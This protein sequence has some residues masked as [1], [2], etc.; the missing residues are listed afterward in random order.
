MIF[1]NLKENLMNEIQRRTGIS[2]TDKS[3]LNMQK[4]LKKQFFFFF[5]VLFSVITI[6]YAS[7]DENVLSN[8]TYIYAAFII[9][10]LLL[11]FILSAQLFDVEREDTLSASTVFLGMGITIFI[12]IGISYFF[13]NASASTFITLNY[14]LGI[15][16]FFVIIGGLAVFYLIFSN[17][18]KK[19]VGAT[20]FFIKL[21]FYIPCLYYDFIAYLKEELK[22]TPS[23]VFIIAALEVIYILLYY[24]LPKLYNYIIKSTNHSILTGPV[25][26]NKEL[27]ISKNDIFIKKDGDSNLK[28]LKNNYVNSNYSISF[29]TYV[30]SGGESN[31]SYI[32]ESTIFNYAG[33]KPKVVYTNNN[34]KP[35]TYI[36]YFTNNEEE[37]VGPTSYEITLPSQKWNNFV[38]NYFNNKADLFI[39]G[40]LERTFVFDQSN[41]P[42]DGRDSDFISVGKNGGLDGAICNVNYNKNILSIEQIRREY[43]FMKYRNPPIIK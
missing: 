34:N 35:D 21:L 1:N 11:G 19:Q 31:S 39:N 6:Y 15:I 4:D 26:L 42:Y 40:K 17:Y 37:N 2:F 43:N 7:T 9:I 41:I 30:N 27:I 32:D 23:V 28:E 22:I 25:K 36:I 33:G 29:W 14:L 24:F 16:L 13:Q 18:L 38:F 8:K 3:L 12:I 10:P 5:F 20:G